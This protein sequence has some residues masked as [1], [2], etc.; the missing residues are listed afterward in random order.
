M[1]KRSELSQKG[2][3]EGFKNA[4]K[5][6]NHYIEKENYIGAFV[7]AFSIFEDRLTACFLLD[8]GLKNET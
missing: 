6:Y 1:A 3:Y 2:K 5:T 7:V 4:F 8:H